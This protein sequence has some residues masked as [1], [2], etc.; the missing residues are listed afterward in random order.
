MQLSETSNLAVHAL[1]YLAGQ[2]AGRRASAI[3]IGRALG[4]SASHV[5]KILPRLAARGWLVS[6]RGASGGYRLA[7]D[8]GRI[9]LLEIVESF[10][11]PWPAGGCLL[12]RPICRP[13]TC[14][15]GGE[16]ARLQ[17]QLR[18]RLRR[19]TIGDFVPGA[20]RRAA[21]GAPGGHRPGGRERAR[22][23]RA[24]GPRET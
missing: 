18:E 24:Q 2:A 23:W 14:L 5:A 16:Y 21:R 4:R 6:S 13:G 10:E 11:G 8:P 15:F 17:G 3:E 20:L 1:A 22:G 12:G 19:T 9:T 7:V